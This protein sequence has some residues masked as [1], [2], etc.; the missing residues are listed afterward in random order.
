MAIHNHIAIITHSAL[1][2]AVPNRKKVGNPLQ[3]YAVIALPPAAQPD[4]EAVLKAVAPG[5]SLAGLSIRAP[6]NANTAKPTPG[7]P[8]DWFVIRAATQFAPYLCDEAGQQLDQATHA[9]DIRQKF[10]PGKRVRVALSAYFWP[11][12]GGG[13]SFNLDGVM[14]VADGERLPIGNQAA[15]VFAGYA[16]PNAQAAPATSNG[17]FGGST[18]TGLSSGSTVVAD[19]FQQSAKSAAANPFA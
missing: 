2:R 3:F 1:E 9:N 16:D 13:L 10:Y 14:A 8:G 11:N 6:R 15:G 18:Q 4:L 12:E 5:G 17:P 19:P 7:V